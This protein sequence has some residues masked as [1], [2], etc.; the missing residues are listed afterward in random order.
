MEFL[1]HLPQVVII[2]LCI[3]IIIGRLEHVV[4]RSGENE[5]NSGLYCAGQAKPT[6][7]L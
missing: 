4:I 6:D 2:F 7:H 5:N 1:R 3:K